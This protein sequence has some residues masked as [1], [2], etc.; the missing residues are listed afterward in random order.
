MY[1]QIRD[2]LVVARQHVDQYNL[3]QQQPMLGVQRLGPQVAPMGVPIAQQMMQAFQQQQQAAY[4][5]Q[6]QEMAF[7]GP[8]NG[9]GQDRAAMNGPASLQTQQQQHPQQ[10]DG[11][12][13]GHPPAAGSGTGVRAAATAAVPRRIQPQAVHGVEQQQQHA[14]ADVVDAAGVTAAGR[15]P[16]QQVSLGQQQAAAAHQQ[17]QQ[18][19][20]K[21]TSQTHNGAAASVQEE[22]QA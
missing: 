3:Q 14:P 19:S 17:Q 21:P 22:Q 5:Q 2:C 10:L 18:H 16:L 12:G 8:A 4:S 20:D 15:Q 13:S 7:T 9:L 11:F 6:Q 1:P